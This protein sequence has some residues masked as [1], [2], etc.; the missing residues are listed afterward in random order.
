MNNVSC[1]QIFFLLCVISI[2]SIWKMDDRSSVPYGGWPGPFHLGEKTCSTEST[3]TMRNPKHKC[4][5]SNALQIRKWCNRENICIQNRFKIQNTNKS[6]NKCDYRIVLFCIIS[7]F[8]VHLK[9]MHCFCSLQCVV[10]FVLTLC[11]GFLDFKKMKPLA[12]VGR[13]S[14]SHNMKLK[15]LGY[16]HCHLVLL[17]WWWVW[18]EATRHQSHSIEFPPIN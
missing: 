16:I 4:K 10:A 11:F 3:E 6:Q 17:M 7:L 8:A 14:S 1:F 13:W 9:F 15:Y 5:T 18:A 2:D 12:P